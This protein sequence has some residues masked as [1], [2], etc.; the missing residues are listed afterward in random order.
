[1]N[2]KHVKLLLERLTEDLESFQSSILRGDP[3]DFVA[4]KETVGKIHGL[5]RAINHVKD[6]YKE[7]LDDDDN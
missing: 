6:V 7:F 1:M 5:S 4:Y 2:Q 3:V